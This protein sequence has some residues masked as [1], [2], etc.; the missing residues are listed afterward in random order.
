M[1]DSWD[2]QE[3]ESG[4]AWIAFQA[5]RDMGAGRRLSDVLPILG[6]TKGYQRQLETYS[7]K[8]NW[9]SRCRDYDNYCDRRNREELEERNRAEYKRRLDKYWSDKEQIARA[10]YQ[11][12]FRAKQFV[13]QQ[14]NYYLQ[15]PAPARLGEVAGLLR[16]I[17]LLHESA[18]TAMLAILER[19][20]GAQKM[21][22]TEAIL[23]SSDDPNEL[24]KEH[25]RLL[26]ELESD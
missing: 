18:D 8:Y 10:D 19:E 12:V 15:N 21:T 9:V 25:Q 5:Y 16:S 2:R 26:D 3:W 14:L 22:Q 17:I 11:I 1:T 4:V 24:V 6:K 13:Q 23:I 20:S 7:S